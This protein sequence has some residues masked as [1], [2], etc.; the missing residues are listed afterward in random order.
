MIK[1]PNESLIFILNQIRFSMTNLSWTISIP[2]Q[3]QLVLW[4]AEPSTNR[5]FRETTQDESEDD[6]NAFDAIQTNREF[7]SNETNESDS[8]YENMM[9]QQFQH[10]AG[11]QLA[12]WIQAKNSEM[13]PT[14]FDS[15]VNFIHTTG[16]K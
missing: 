5:T 1:T 12:Q 9:I 14:Q 6:P 7:D 15:I 2:V 13:H 3:V 4:N 10:S 16:M 8:Q 11:F